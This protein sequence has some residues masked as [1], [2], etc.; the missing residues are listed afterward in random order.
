VSAISINRLLN[1]IHLWK[2]YGLKPG[3]PRAGKSGFPDQI[4]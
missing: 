2:R 1:L 3:K 4:R